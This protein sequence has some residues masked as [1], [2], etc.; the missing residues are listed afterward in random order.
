VTELDTRT[1]GHFYLLA[2]ALERV[3]DRWPCS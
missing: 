1:Y 2:K 3:G